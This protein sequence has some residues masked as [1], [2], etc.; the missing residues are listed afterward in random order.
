M[1][2][3]TLNRLLKEFSIR[4]CMRSRKIRLAESECFWRSNYEPE[5]EKPEKKW[6]KFSYVHRIIGN[7]NVNE[8]GDYYEFCKLCKYSI[9][10][11]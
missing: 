1:L 4:T 11:S 10:F 3:C 7:E 5:V 6:D 9:N 2:E 8:T